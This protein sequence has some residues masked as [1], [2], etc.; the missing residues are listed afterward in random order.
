MHMLQHAKLS[1]SHYRNLV[2]RHD[3]KSFAAVS[4]RYQMSHAPDT[5]VTK[6]TDAEYI[7]THI[8]VLVETCNQNQVRFILAQTT[9]Q[10]VVQL[11]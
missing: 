9:A 6:V 5:I 7:A 10:N 3:Y 4:K 11:I 2:L 1:L 8:A